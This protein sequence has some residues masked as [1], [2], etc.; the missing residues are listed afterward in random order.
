MCQ[1]EVSTPSHHNNPLVVDK[2][3]NDSLVFALAIC[4]LCITQLCH[5]PYGI[6]CLALA[7][8]DPVK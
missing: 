1:A 7:D 4:A 3:Y 2:Y 8:F 5:P 6:L